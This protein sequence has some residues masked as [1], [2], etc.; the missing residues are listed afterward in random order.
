M[1]TVDEEGSQSPQNYVGHRNACGDLLQCTELHFSSLYRNLVVY[2]RCREV[3]KLFRLVPSP[4]SL[5]GTVNYV[6]IRTF[7]H[8]RRTFNMLLYV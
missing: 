8:Y 1:L 2:C 7:L 6:Q 5:M 3:I 4:H